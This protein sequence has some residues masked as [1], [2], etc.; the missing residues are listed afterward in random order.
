M[1]SVGVVTNR[2]HNVTRKTIIQKNI[3]FVEYQQE[4]GISCRLL[5][6]RRQISN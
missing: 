1:F 6:V 4:N 3:L 2:E 5:E